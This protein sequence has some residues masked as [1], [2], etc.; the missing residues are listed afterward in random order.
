MKILDTAGV[1]ASKTPKVA[2]GSLEVEL[3]GPA[4]AAPR[5]LHVT[6]Q[7]NDGPLYEVIVP[8]GN[9]IRLRVGGHG[10]IVKDDQ[11]RALAKGRADQ[12]VQPAASADVAT[13]VVFRVSAG[14]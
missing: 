7:E 14:N 9:P 5:S 6:S 2:S 10:V 3:L 4:G 8:A 11:G 13:K 12:Q 1:L